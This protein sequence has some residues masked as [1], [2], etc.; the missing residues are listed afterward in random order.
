MSEHNAGSMMGGFL[1]GA[2]VGAGVALIF[3]PM[4]GK[5]TR[6]H[7]GDAARRLKVG[8]QD[9]MDH[10]VGAIKEGADDIGAAID[11]GKDAYRRSTAAA[12][13]DRPAR[14]PVEERT[15]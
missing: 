12:T 3:A 4:N 8:T 2:V 14:V 9:R 11:A 15:T 6:R 7:I 1:L 13:N 5:D 10:V